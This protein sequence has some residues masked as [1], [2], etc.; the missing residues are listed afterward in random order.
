MDFSKAFDS[1]KHELLARK[2][3]SLQLNPYIINLYLSFWKGR[4][5]RIC[6][7]NISCD[8]K[9]VNQ[10]TTQ[11][12]ASGPYVFNIFIN[13]LEIYLG[14][15]PCQCYSSMLMTQISL[16]P[17]WKDRDISEVLVTQ[18]FIWTERNG[19]LCNPG[20]CKEVTVLKKCNHELYPPIF[21][22]RSCTYISILGVTFQ[23]DCKFNTHVE[24]KL[25]KAN[26]CLYVLRSL[27]KEGYKQ[28]EIDF[29]FDA[30]VLP[31]L[32]YALSVYGPSESDL[33]PVQCFLDHCWRSNFTT[34]NYNIRSILQK[35][36]H[37][38]FKRVCQAANHRLSLFIPC[39]KACC[40]N[41]G[42]RSSVRPSIKSERF[43][44][45]SIFRYNLQYCSF[46]IT[47]SQNFLFF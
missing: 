2:L 38:I 44:N 35:Q 3:K 27:C 5:Q 20:K 10:G 21:G 15:W 23:R 47:R 13:D 25:V 14:W 7:N 11:G 26:K 41:L 40:Y 24:N 33:T 39:V 4:K 34:R 9:Y 17:V 46:R 32:T 43:K 37:S 8:W 18:F 31:N 29:L 12:S 6:Y 1:V 30:L 28:A 36:D 42:T 16:P 19:M 22:I 45:R